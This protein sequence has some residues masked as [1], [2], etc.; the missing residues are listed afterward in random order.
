MT[1]SKIKAGT[2]ELTFRD[3]DMPPRAK[4]ILDG[5]RSGLVFA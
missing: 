5:Y 4:L 2:V 3:V 1:Y